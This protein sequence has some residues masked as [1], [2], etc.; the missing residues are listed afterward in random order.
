MLGETRRFLYDS[1]GLMPPERPP[2]GWNPFLGYPRHGDDR[3]TVREKWFNE[4]VYN[5]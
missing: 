2:A 5:L 4:E 1:R 3:N